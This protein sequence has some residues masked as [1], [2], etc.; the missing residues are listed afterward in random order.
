MLPDN[1]KYC[2]DLWCY[3]LALE[4]LKWLNYVNLV[5]VIVV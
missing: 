3:G 4:L 5:L 1:F 2:L